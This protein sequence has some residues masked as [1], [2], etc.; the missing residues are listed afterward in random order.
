MDKEG[1]E[2]PKLEEEITE[3]TAASDTVE[4]G[5]LTIKKKILLDEEESD[6]KYGLQEPPVKKRFIDNQK[7]KVE[8]HSAKRVLER[9]AK[10]G[11]KKLLSFYDEEEEEIEE[12]NRE[13]FKNKQEKEE[14]EREEDDE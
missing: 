5:Q 11:N 8:T 7:G 14:E 9:E 13:V 1:K 10:S 4:A 12:Y 3:A 2:I 6:K